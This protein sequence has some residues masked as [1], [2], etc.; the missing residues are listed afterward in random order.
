MSRQN[1]FSDVL[2][3]SVPA[4]EAWAALEAMDRWLPTLDTVQSVEPDHEGSRDHAVELK[5]GHRYFVR[6]GEGPMMHCRI[7]EADPVAGVVRI[8]ARLGPLKSRLLCTIEPMGLSSCSLRRRQ[9]YPGL[10]GRIFT[11]LLGRREQAE[12]TAYLRAWAD[13]ANDQHAGDRG[14]AP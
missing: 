11:L 4:A 3:V 5:A 13:Y 7:V 9:T 2:R 12:T 1:D 10:I 14:T 8:E 6:T